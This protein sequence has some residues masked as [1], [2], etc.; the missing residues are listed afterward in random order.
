MKINGVSLGCTKKPKDEA[1]RAALVKAAKWKSGDIIT[2]SFL[3][4]M[5]SIQEKV[6]QGRQNLGQTRN[7]EFET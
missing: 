5:P 3:D 4:G 1:T 6:K 7:G 2:V